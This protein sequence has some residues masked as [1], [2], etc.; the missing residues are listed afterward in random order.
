MKKRV[1][2]FVVE[3]P[4]DQDALIPFIENEIQVNKMRTTVKNMHRDILTKYIEGTRKYEIT[5]S[6][7]RK[8]LTRKI[9]EYL[10]SP[11]VKSEQIK[12]KDLRKIYYITDTDY[13]FIKENE[14]SKNKRECLKKIFSFEKLKLKNNIEVEIETIFFSKHLEHVLK[15]IEENLPNEEKAKIAIEFSK[16]SLRNR[17]FYISTFKTQEN[18]KTWDSFSEAYAGI[19]SYDKRAC[20]MN[21]LLDD[22]EEWKNIK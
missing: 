6:N 5:P 22:I 10:D 1:V 11:I 19:Q 18:L 20:N 16:E 9:D 17:E 8:E 12:R 13:C 7:M 15:N 21:N 3:G 2:L 14:H 4:S